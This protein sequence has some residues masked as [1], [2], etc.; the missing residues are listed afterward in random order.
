MS[1]LNKLNWLNHQKYKEINAF[2]IISKIIKP[3]NIK[4]LPKQISLI[5]EKDH[6]FDSENFLIKVATQI[7]LEIKNRVEVIKKLYNSE[8][9]I[10][11]EKFLTDITGIQPWILL[12][13]KNGGLPQ[14]HEDLVCCYFVNNHG[15]ANVKNN[16]NS[17]NSIL[18]TARK[19]NRDWDMD[20][21]I[22][23][24]FGHASIAPIPLI[25]QQK[26]RE[27]LTSTSTTIL[28][29]NL[30]YPIVESIN[31]ILRGEKRD[32]E[33]GLAVIETEKELKV[34]I[35]RCKRE[36]PDCG[37]QDIEVKNFVNSEMNKGAFAI[38]C[39]RAVRKS[40]DK[41]LKR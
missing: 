36:F 30:D 28:D 10:Q 17:F 26:Q 12:E 20:T 4:Y 3:E 25:G 31:I 8:G 34:F 37:F 1:L 23:H 15:V 32:C 13:T 40:K 24:E 39:M 14:G 7:E 33:T 22:G 29:I 41:Y 5:V 27:D 19:E 11:V 35:E 18:V 21:D 6:N 38:A 2:K 16:P 9:Q